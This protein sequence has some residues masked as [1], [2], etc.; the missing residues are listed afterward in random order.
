MLGGRCGWVSSRLSSCCS[1]MFGCFEALCCQFCCI[2][3]ALEYPRIGT[4]HSRLAFRADFR[5]IFHFAPIGIHLSLCTMFAYPVALA[6]KKHRSGKTLMIRF[7]CRP[8]IKKRK[9]TKER[10]PHTSQKPLAK[11]SD[12]KCGCRAQRRQ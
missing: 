4:Q 6:S 2:S 8:F 12:L 1:H 9:G 5:S 3:M 10:N 7:F 11:T